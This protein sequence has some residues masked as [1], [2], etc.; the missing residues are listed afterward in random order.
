MNVGPDMQYSF[1][2]GCSGSST[3]GGGNGGIT[4]STDDVIFPHI[5][6]PVESALK[7]EALG[8]ESNDDGGGDEVDGLMWNTKD[9]YSF[10]YSAQSIDLANWK[11]LFP[12]EIHVSRFWGNSPLRL[13]LYE[14]ESTCGG[15]MKKPKKNYV[16]EL[17]LEYLGS[18]WT[19][20]EKE[21][22]GCGEEMSR[23]D[24]GCRPLPF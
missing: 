22:D 8:G 13:V 2:D 4:A 14:T 20:E 9:T 16:F 19:G 17:Q 23:C 5:T 10:T 7:V 11:L 3:F 6:F 24:D 15:N 18:P 1:G 12:F 21:G